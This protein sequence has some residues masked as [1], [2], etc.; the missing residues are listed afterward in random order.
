MLPDSGKL[1]VNKVYISVKTVAKQ[2]ADSSIDWVT[3][4]V[5]PP[6]AIAKTV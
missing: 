3:L 6:S 4:A 5:A 1:Y 2:S